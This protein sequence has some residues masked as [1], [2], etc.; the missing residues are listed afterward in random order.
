MLKKY[1]IKKSSGVE[2]HF[3]RLKLERSIARTGLRK[4]TC[5]DISATIEKNIQDCSTTKDIYKKTFKL[6]KKHSTIAAAHYS[7]KKSLQGLGPTGYE[8]EAFVAKYFESIGYKTKVSIVLQ[9]E[10]VSHEV[11]VYALK[12]DFITCVEC[13]FHN[14]NWRKND[15]KTTLYVKARWD[16]LKNGPEGKDLKEFFIASNTSFTKDAIKF[17]NGVGLK[18]LGVNAPESESFLDKI[19]MHK[20]YPITS[21]S[22]LK[23]NIIKELLGKNIILCSEL[24][25]EQ[26]TLKTL[27]L[28]NEEI[29]H[30][31]SDINLLLNK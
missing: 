31:F 3:N 7:L 8:F 29:S 27:G 12:N 9:G 23:K 22:R 6:I 17:A 4:K 16:D 25:N 5:K 26:K 21:L 18:L 14:N 28:S 1:K 13:K 19:E 20:L 15:I 10:F 30:I 24:L 2:E 11:D